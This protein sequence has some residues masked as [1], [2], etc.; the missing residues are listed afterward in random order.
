MW[1]QR[2]GDLATATGEPECQ[3]RHHCVTELGSEV[4]AL[5]LVLSPYV[6]S[7]SFYILKVEIVL[8]P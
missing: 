1:V 4:K 2:T 8:I 3:Y 5:T 7:V 6:L